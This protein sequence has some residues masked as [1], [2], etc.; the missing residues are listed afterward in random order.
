[1]N[2][3]VLVRHLPVA[4]AHRGRWIGGG[5]DVDADPDARAAAWEGLDALRTAWPPDAVV[6]SP[7]RRA[8]QT[9]A[10]VALPVITD[11]RLR[12]RHFGVWEGR[13]VDE[14]MAT[15]PASATAGTAAWRAHP[16][17]GAE[18]ADE[19]SARVRT[20]FHDLAGTGGVVWC[21]AHAGTLVVLR[22][23]ALGISEDEAFDDPLA[24]GGWCVIDVPG[25][26]EVGRGSLLPSGL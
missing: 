21:I 12:E 16:I 18:S 5:T 26:R 19:V 20:L 7:L 4:N 6:C 14:V 8:Q 1:M 13:P 3:L 15:V 25:T 10:V 22:A 2:T 23:L 24:R 11:V 9:A 17:E